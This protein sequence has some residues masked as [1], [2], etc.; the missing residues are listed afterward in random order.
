MNTSNM[1]RVLRFCLFLD[2]QGPSLLIHYLTTNVDI[3]SRNVTCAQT[4]RVTAT[5]Q[6]S[7]KF[8]PYEGLSIT[9][10]L[11]RDKQ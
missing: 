11:V 8:D 9:Y 1:H 6:I 2:F 5:S 3:F 4:A 10:H 7:Y